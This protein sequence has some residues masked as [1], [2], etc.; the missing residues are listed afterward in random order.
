MSYRRPRPWWSRE[1]AVIIRR[2]S[3]PGRGDTR[4]AGMPGGHDAPGFACAAAR[5]ERDSSGLLDALHG[6]AHRGAD[7]SLSVSAHLLSARVSAHFQTQ[8]PA[9]TSRLSDENERSLTVSAHLDGELLDGLEFGS[10]CMLPGP[11]AVLSRRTRPEATAPDSLRPDASFPRCG[12]LKKTPE[13]STP[14]AAS[15]RKLAP[16]KHSRLR[17]CRSFPLSEPATRPRKRGSRR[18]SV[19]K[20]SGVVAPKRA[21][22]FVELAQACA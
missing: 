21:A 5:G 7:L 2:R 4:P 10:A 12:K 18:E 22:F 19:R 16:R 17:A 1:Q 8:K 13:S 3:P 6:A 20:L 11:S 14:K 15:S 9:P